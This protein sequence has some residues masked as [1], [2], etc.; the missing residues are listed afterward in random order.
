YYAFVDG[1][2][3]ARIACR[4]QLEKGNLSTVGGHI[5]YQTAPKFRRQG[6]MTKLLNFALEEYGKRGISPVLITAREDNVAS[7]KTIEN[8]GGVLENIIDLEDGQ[9]LARY[10]IRLEK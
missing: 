5:G 10:W 7:R 6:I 4:W 1:S 3:A 9:R 8:A 2:I